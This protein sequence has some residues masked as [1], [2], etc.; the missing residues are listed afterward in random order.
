ML[1]SLPNDFV[2]SFYSCSEKRKKKSCQCS[3]QATRTISIL[4]SQHSVGGKALDCFP[5][6]DW[7]M[8]HDLPLTTVDCPFCIVL[9]VKVGLCFCLFGAGCSHSNPPVQSDFWWS[10]KRPKN[11]T[12]IKPVNAHFQ[13]LMVRFTCN[14]CIAGSRL[15]ESPL[16][17]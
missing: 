15:S 8:S 12:K 3:I 16:F 6:I 14:S 5:A 4:K 7:F 11:V 13:P 17:I 1:Q 10:K 2:Y 9:W